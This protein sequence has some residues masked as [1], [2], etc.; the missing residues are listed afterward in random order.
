M[1]DRLAPGDGVARPDHEL[2]EVGLRA[3]VATR[4]IL[5]AAIV[6][7]RARRG[8]EKVGVPECD[9]RDEKGESGERNA[10]LHALQSTPARTTAA[11]RRP[12]PSLPPERS[13]GAG[14]SR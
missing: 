5:Q 4:R 7:R 13:R 6:D 10:E 1:I 12:R 9:G 8:L 14:C 11:I 2:G 3:N